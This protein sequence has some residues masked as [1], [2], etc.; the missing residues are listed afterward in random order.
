M[1]CCPPPLRV[2]TTRTAAGGRSLTGGTISHRRRQSILLVGSLMSILW[3]FSSLP[4]SKDGKLILQWLAPASYFVLRRNF[5]HFVQVESRLNHPDY[6]PAIKIQQWWV[7]LGCFQSRYMKEEK[8]TWPNSRIS[9]SRL[10]LSS[11][12][13]QHLLLLR[14]PSRSKRKADALAKDLLLTLRPRFFSKNMGKKSSLLFFFPIRSL[15][16]V[17]GLFDGCRSNRSVI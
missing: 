17:N 15:W 4:R 2:Y 3:F 5:R 11:I 10:L 14:I 16:C 9:G 12:R 7:T 8:K 13:L 1:C 6:F